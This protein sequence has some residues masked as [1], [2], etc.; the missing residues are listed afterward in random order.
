MAKEFLYTYTVIHANDDIAHFSSNMQPP[1]AGQV[2]DLSDFD[3][4]GW[5]KFRVISVVVVPHNPIHED[6]NIPA[7]DSTSVEIYVQPES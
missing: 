4:P 7:S 6:G 1:V 5:H 3:L 2:L